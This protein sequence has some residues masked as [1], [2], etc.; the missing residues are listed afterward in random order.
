MVTPCR[1]LN[2]GAHYYLKGFAMATGTRRTAAKKAP[3]K[4]AAA[5]KSDGKNTAGQKGKD[6]IENHADESGP[7]EDND[8][9]ADA[10]A[11]AAAELP[12]PG[13]KPGDK[14]E[15]VQPDLKVQIVEGDEDEETPKESEL[16]EK[17]FVFTHNLDPARQIPGT[18]QYLD[19]KQRSDAEVQRAIVEDR[20]PDL[21]NPPSMQ[22]TPYKTKAEIDMQLPLEANVDPDV[23]LEV[24]QVKTSDE[25]KA[26]NDKKSEGNTSNLL[27][28]RVGVNA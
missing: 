18:N 22:G 25:D 1:L 27:N 21:E 11:A 8:S 16:V 14:I 4:K 12:G 24:S 15:A 6:A 7:T 3:A 19:F 26:E 17:G 20:E 2:V 9:S 28:K 23:V 5:S 13:L 10:R